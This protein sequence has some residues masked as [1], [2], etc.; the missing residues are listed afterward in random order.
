MNY[1]VG[2]ILESE[3]GYR[4]KVYKDTDGELVGKLV[5][6]K[7]HSCANIPYSLSG[8]HKLIKRTRI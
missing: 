8:K 6:K 1:R 5:C 7:G 4:V 2:D 3:W